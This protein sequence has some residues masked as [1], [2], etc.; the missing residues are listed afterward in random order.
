MDWFNREVASIEGEAKHFIDQ[1]FKT[2]RSAEGAFDLLQSFKHIGSRE[3]IDTQ[4]MKKFNGILL[5]YGNE[6][7]FLGRGQN[8]RD[9]CCNLFIDCH[10]SVEQVDLMDNLYQEGKKDPPLYKHCPPM[11]GSIYWE[12]SLFLRINTRSSDSSPWRR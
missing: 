3:A 2:L 10:F 9:C 12:K 6:V 8:L 11:S 1:S 7:I 5:Q 4:M